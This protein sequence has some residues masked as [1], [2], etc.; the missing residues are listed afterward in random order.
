MTSHSSLKRINDRY[1]IDR[2]KYATKYVK[3]SI[4]DR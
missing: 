3:K 2:E 4:T 1:A